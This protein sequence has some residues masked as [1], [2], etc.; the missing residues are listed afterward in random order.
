MDQIN[1]YILSTVEADQVIKTEE[2]Q[3]LWSGYGSIKR[4]YLEGSTLSKVIVKH[5]QLSKVKH[6]PRGWN[7]DLSHQRKVKSY[8]VETNFYENYA[9]LTDNECRL[10]QCIGVGHFGEDVVIIME[11]L[12]ESGFPARLGS[13]SF[14]EMKGCIRWLAYFHARYLNHSSEGLWDIGTYWHLDTRPDELQ[15]MDDKALK[16]AASKIDQKLNNAK[17]K[18]LVHGDAKVANFCFS[19]DHNKVAAVDFQYIGGGVG[20]KDLAYFVG[21]CLYEEDC[22]NYE[23][24]I[25]NYYFSEFENA[26]CHY[27]IEVDFDELKKE[28]TELYPVAWSDFHRFLKGWSPGHWKINSY[29]ERIARQVVAS[30]K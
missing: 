16:N 14:N 30:L 26:I 6:H 10:P 4:Y 28:W 8:E 11:D 1:Q 27:Q 5:V 29:S 25:L 13:I 12:D 22:E 9:Q 2:I 18:T 19:N 17:Y 15:V 23:S 21:S 7:T 3:S 20:M 24:D